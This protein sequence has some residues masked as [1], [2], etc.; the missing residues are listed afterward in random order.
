MREYGCAVKRTRSPAK[1]GS[2]ELGYILLSCRGALVAV[3]VF[4]AVSNILALSGSLFMMEV[5]NRVLPS[6]SLPTLIGL[7][8]L[9]LVLLGTQGLLELLRA[10]LLVRIGELLHNRS[11]E[12]VFNCQ[13]WLPVKTGHAGSGLHPVKD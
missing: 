11:C 6:R 9:L 3:G 12:R 7:S 2:A 5:Y 10:R 4:S 13:I 8:V 1:Y